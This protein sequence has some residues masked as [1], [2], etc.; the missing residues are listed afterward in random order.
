MRKTTLLWLALAVFCGAVLFHTSQKVTDGRGKLAELQSNI[1]AEEESLRV[2]QAE[3]SYLNQPERLEK[4]S[5]QYLELSPMTGRQFAEAEDISAAPPPEEKPAPEEKEITVKA[6]EK[7]IVKTT[8]KP[9]TA[10]KEP[11]KKTAAPKIVRPSSFAAQ[12]VLRPAA[13][14][15][16]VKTAAPAT[17]SN[18]D[19]S[20]LIKSLGVQ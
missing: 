16:T 11:A 1:R 12:S 5:R 15:K 4:L 13:P 7:T 19:F 10:Q 8:V 20:D 17:A 3:W 14:P 9:Q 6:P 2:L 18:R